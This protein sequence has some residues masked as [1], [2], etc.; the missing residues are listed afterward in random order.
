MLVALPHAHWQ[1]L[2][3]V[4]RAEAAGQAPLG[5]DLRLTPTRKTKDGAFLDDLV[6]EGLL[7]AAGKPQSG[8]GQPEPF[9]RRY[10]L[11][12]LGRHAA[13]YGEYDRPYTPGD[14]PVTGTAAEVLA[15]RAAQRTWATP[16]EQ[17]PRRTGKKA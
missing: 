9:R 1:V 15:S 10:R 6:S 3:A 11:T 4:L 16:A 14:V 7:A 2:R 5:R 17:P 13:E 8:D 12:A